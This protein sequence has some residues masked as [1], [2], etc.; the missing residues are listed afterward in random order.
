MSDQ[1]SQLG[2]FL[3]QR[4]WFKA[5]VERFS[6][7]KIPAGGFS[8]VLFL[9]DV[10]LSDKKGKSISAKVADHVWVFANKEVFKVGKE[11][12]EGDEISFSAVVDT[13]SIKRQDIVD[14]RNNVQQAV[15]LNNKQ[16][17][18]DYREN[19]VD[20]KDDWQKV[21]QR[22]QAIKQ[23]FQE[24]QIDRKTMQQLEQANIDQYKNRQPNGVAV[25]KEEEA[26]KQQAKIDQQALKYI[27]YQLVDLRQVKFIKQRRLRKGWIRKQIMEKDQSNRKFTKYL[28]ARSFAYKDGIAYDEFINK[29]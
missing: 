6:H 28:A 11:L 22:N 14:K 19:Y 3:G 16:I 25:K 17:F 13:Y 24:G 23:Q 15:N 1:R 29:K 26:N 20:W 27:D 8:P 10:Q 7:K 12:F 4:L 5:T 9:L 21:A 2:E 18:Q